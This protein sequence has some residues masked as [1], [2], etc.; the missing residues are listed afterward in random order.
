MDIDTVKTGVNIN[1]TKLIQNF[2][3]F[4]SIDL[5]KQIFVPRTST[6]LTRDSILSDSYNFMI[7]NPTSNFFTSQNKEDSL[8]P[9]RI[10]SNT[11]LPN[12][13]ANPETFLIFIHGG[14]YLAC[15]SKSAQSFTKTWAIDLNLPVFCI[16]Y[17]LAPENKF[18]KG[19]DD[20][21]Q[22]YVWLVN[23]SEE[24]FGVI[25]KKIIL[26]GGSAGAAFSIK[27]AFLCKKIGFRKPDGLLLGYSCLSL[28]SK[29][30]LKATWQVLK[31]RILASS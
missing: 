19:L 9:L 24:C 18:P 25:P 13:N 4:P 14:G 26:I 2:N 22:A 28:D 17:H 31:T 27:I 6:E 8:I 20:V 16:D 21:W 10:L 3:T 30:C 11:K 15:T 1:E 7:F 29:N 12:V 5:N 23:N